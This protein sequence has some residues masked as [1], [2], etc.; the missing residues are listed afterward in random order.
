MPTLIVDPEGR[1]S[2]GLKVPAPRKL[3]SLDGSVV[4][5]LDNAKPGTRELFDGMTPRLR[6]P[7]T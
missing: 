3:S 6:G 7:I 2:T 5:F 1:R 4:G